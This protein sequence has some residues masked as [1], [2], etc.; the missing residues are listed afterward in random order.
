MRKRSNTIEDLDTIFN[1]E[2]YDPHCSNSDLP[3]TQQYITYLTP[4][5]VHAHQ[6]DSF[7]VNDH[8]YMQWVEGEY[9]A[10]LKALEKAVN[11]KDEGNTALLK[12]A[13][14]S[15]EKRGSIESDIENTG[16]IQGANTNSS[17][18]SS[19]IEEYTELEKT[20]IEKLINQ[21][22]KQYDR[23]VNVMMVGERMTG[24]TTFIHTF[25]NSTSPKAPRKTSGYSSK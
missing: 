2:E 23:L 20:M 6:H 7:I 16:S 5:Q 8:K 25:I 12:R 9:T 15:L 18:N 22:I 10:I 21:N 1:N 4:K 11:Q 3:N 14:L 19:D 17:E 24:K 13:L